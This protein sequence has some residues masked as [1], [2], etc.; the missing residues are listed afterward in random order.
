MADSVKRAYHSTHRAAAAAARRARIRQAA[1]RLFVEQGYAA[2]SMRQVAAAA[3]VGERTLY[4]AFPSK[5]AL[6][7]HA[8]DVAVVGDEEPVAVAARPEITAAR[9]ESD[10]QAALA[11]HIAYTV[12]LLD[13]A[14]DLIMV[15]VEAAGTDADMRA[16]AD[17]GS[18]ATHR[19]HL[20]LTESLHARGALHPGLTPEAAADL[21]YALLSPHVHQLLRRHRSWSS[22]RYRTWLE[23]SLTHQLLDQPHP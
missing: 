17:A 16:A 4:D 1:A 23:L 10:P 3:E 20:A 2:T 9:E 21:L 5:A 14:A 22:E 15:S 6:F 13:R 7:S 8:L 12:A 11:Q 18:A 19:V